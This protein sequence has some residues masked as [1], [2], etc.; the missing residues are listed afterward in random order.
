MLYLAVS[1]LLMIRHFYYFQDDSIFSSLVFASLFCFIFLSTFYLTS[2]IYFLLLLSAFFF[3]LPSA[4]LSRSV[5]PLS[6]FLLF[7][8]AFHA[9]LLR[10]LTS[11]L[12]SAFPCF[13]SIYVTSFR[14]VFW[15]A[16]FLLSSLI[17]FLSPD[18]LF[19]NLLNYLL[20]IQYCFFLLLL[21]WFCSLVAGLLAS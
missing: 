9:A 5:L 2:P 17:S 8:S 11:Y 12:L 20:L 7:S 16:F 6:I 1:F 21:S 10:Y 18:L 14:V 4:T 13:Y 19:F 15:S 3:C